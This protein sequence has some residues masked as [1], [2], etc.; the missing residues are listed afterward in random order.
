MSEK[1]GNDDIDPEYFVRKI[2]GLPKRPKD[3]K[4]DNTKYDLFTVLT[5]PLEIDN[6]YNE[7]YFIK[8]INEI[9]ISE[10]ENEIIIVA[11]DEGGMKTATRIA[12]KLNCEVA[13]IYKQR[14]KANE[15]AT[16]KLIILILW[17]IIMKLKSIIIIIIF[18]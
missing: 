11:H 8:Y 1:I 12:N 14:E 6:L 3:I 17:E 5:D 13:S 10:S 7:I 15:V 18:P 4:Q 9:I 16:M 2:I